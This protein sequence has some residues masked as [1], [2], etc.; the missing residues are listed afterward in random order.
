MDNVHADDLLDHWGHRPSALLSGLLSQVQDPGEDVAQFEDLLEA[1]RGVDSGTYVPGLQ[2]GDTV[3]VLGHRR[4]VT[5][6]RWSGGPADTLSIGF[7]L[8]HATE[9][10]RGGRVVQGGARAC[11]QGAAAGASTT[12]GR[13]GSA[14]QASPRAG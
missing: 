9:E 14:G 11:G 1:A 7:D 2:E 5:Y 3:T 12:H 10:I 4:D 8:E 6:G 13:S